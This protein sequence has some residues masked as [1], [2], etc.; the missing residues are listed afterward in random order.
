M[1][2]TNLNKDNFTSEIGEGVVLVDFW[3][4]WCGPCK[5]IAPILDQLN[6]DLNGKAQIKKLNID[7]YGEI[8]QQY[9]IMSIPTM[10]VFKDG[11]PVDKALGYQPKENLANLLE[12]HI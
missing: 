4:P 11:K 6:Q 12:K 3:A 10:L 7:E 1:A 9:E 2:I 8:A 5:M